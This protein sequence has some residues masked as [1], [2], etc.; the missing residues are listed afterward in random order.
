M[1][2]C[3]VTRPV[4]K[5]CEPNCILQSRD[6]YNVK[7]PHLV[8]GGGG[9]V[10]SYVEQHAIASSEGFQIVLEAIYVNLRYWVI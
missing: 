3:I 7:P 4:L 8:G 5:A 1:L 6:C 9:R 10:A 2:F